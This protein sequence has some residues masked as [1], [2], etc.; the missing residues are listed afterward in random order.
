[1]SN[2]E[3]A[4]S[5]LSSQAPIR[6]AVRQV[7]DQELKR[8]VAERERLA[9]Q[10][11]FRQGG[12]DV[13]VNSSSSSA[14]RP[15]DNKENLKILADEAKMTTIVKKDFF[16]RVVQSIPLAEIN[17]NSGDK[18]AKKEEKVWVTYHEGMNNAVRKPMSLQDF[19]K[20]L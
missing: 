5:L 16:G 13:A 3:T 9:R 14:V 4:S 8:T 19:M 2:F 12:G 1:M 10:A 17:G 18:K 15:F 11:R 6:Y 20:G 7:L